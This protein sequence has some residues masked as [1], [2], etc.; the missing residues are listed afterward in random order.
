MLDM[1]QGVDRVLLRVPSLVAG[2]GY[3]RDVLGMR[4]LREDARAAVFELGEAELVLHASE[5]LPAMGVYFR[6]EKLGEL[7]QLRDDL[8]LRFV[9]PP[10]TT[11][12]G[13]SATVRDPFGNVLSLVEV[14]PETPADGSDPAESA[15]GVEPGLFGP[16]P[17]VPDVKPELLIR[18]Y[19]EAGRTADDL[20]YTH[21]FELIY[22]AYCAA[23]ERPP[24]RAEVW[25]HLLRL[26]K[27]GKLPQLGKS[28][29]QPP[30]VSEAQRQLLREM[31]GDAIG[32][33]DRLPYTAELERLREA[34]EARTG[35]RLSPHQFWRLVAVLAK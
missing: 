1:L 30:E 4:L 29:S 5:D 17:V 28:H 2:V 33:R 14:Q 10:R 9:A 27:A 35:E 6:A 24:D 15:G 32:R 19:T 12:R 20:P 18:L 22:D 11:S 21:H 23:F 16:I 25:T 8:R 3:Y 7:Y 26:R 31:M 34:F 13:M